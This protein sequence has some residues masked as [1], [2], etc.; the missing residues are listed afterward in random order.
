MRIRHSLSLSV[1]ALLVPLGAPLNAQTEPAGAAWDR[2]ITPKGKPVVMTIYHSPDCKCC[3]KWITHVKAHGYEVKDMEDPHMLAIKA[4]FSIPKKAL[5]C[6]TAVVGD[7]LVEGHVPATDIDRLLKERPKLRGIAAADMPMG[8]PGMEIGAHK[9]PF[10]VM[11][12][13]EKGTTGPFQV[14]DKY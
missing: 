1:L 6:H 4:K 8:S 9:E 5:S 7:Y 3:K 10:T 14:H 2:N 11:G 12:F 13:D